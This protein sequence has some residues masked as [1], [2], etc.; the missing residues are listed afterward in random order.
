MKILRFLL[1][2]IFCASL[3]AAAGSNPGAGF[4]GGNNGGGGGG[5]GTPITSCTGALSGC[6]Q[7]GA[8]LAVTSAGPISVAT[9]TLSSAQIKAADLTPRIIVAAPGAGKAIQLIAPPFIQYKFG[10]IQYTAGGPLGGGTGLGFNYGSVSS[11]IQLNVAGIRDTAFAANFPPS[12]PVFAAATS[13]NAIS[14]L[15]GAPAL[16]NQP[17]VFGPTSESYNAGP[18]IS[19]TIAVPGS[20]YAVND[21]LNIDPVGFF[22]DTNDA[23]GHVTSIGAGGSVTGV[24][25]DIPGVSY[26]LTTANIA[27]G[28]YPTVHTSGAGDNAL[29][30]N[31]TDV[32]TGDGT[33]VIT[34]LYQTITL[35]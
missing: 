14:A 34:A 5:G 10:T 13:V 30:L 4:G 25:I 23:T 35:Q 29:T 20:G 19:A 7:A 26:L 15:F 8:V 16:A 1:V 33:A 17:I 21:A 11:N 3:A 22:N 28:P 6:T 24:A 27:S 18:I 2:I 12:L 32:T 31:V 9:V